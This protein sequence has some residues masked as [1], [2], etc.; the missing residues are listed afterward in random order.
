MLYG[1]LHI[2]L[3]SVQQAYQ[4]IST[5]G[6]RLLMHGKWIIPNHGTVSSLASVGKHKNIQLFWPGWYFRKPC[7]FAEV[8]Y[9][10]MRLAMHH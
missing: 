2:W 10:E 6:L 3:T 4:L 9:I 5:L 1:R 7:A 8:L